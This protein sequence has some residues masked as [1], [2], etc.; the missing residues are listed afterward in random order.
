MATTLRGPAIFLAQFAGDSVPFDSWDAIT[1]RAASLG[2]DG[3][4]LLSLDGRFIDLKKAAESKPLDSLEF[5]DIYHTRIRALHVKDA[6]F[7]RPAGKA[8][9]RATRRGSRRAGRFRS[10]GDGQVDFRAIFSKM[11]Q[12]DFDGGRCWSGITSFG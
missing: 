8:C 5:I 11:A 10:L 4:Q 12:Y 9:T 3:V 7:R 1:R 6:E 2:L